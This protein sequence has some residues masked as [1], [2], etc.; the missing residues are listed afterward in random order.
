ME[1]AFDRKVFKQMEQSTKRMVDA[2]YSQCLF[3]CNEKVSTDL[4]ACKQACYRNVIVPYKIVQHQATDAEENLYRKCLADKLPQITQ[5]DYVTCTKN[6]YAQRV[7][8]MMGH[9]ANSAE[10][11]LTS[12]H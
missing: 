4:A 12:I 2:S 1:S 3:A 10:S 8:L 11:L 9:F 5:A 6:V 7:E